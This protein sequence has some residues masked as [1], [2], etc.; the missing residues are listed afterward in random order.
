MAATK[1]LLEQSQKAYENYMKLSHYLLGE[2]APMD[3]KDIPE[4]NPYYEPAKK[5]AEE[6]ELDWDKM[7]HEDSIRV[8]INLL[9]DAYLN[10]QTDE[11]YIPVLTI[12]FK[13]KE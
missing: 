9:S 13:K 4:D 7:S 6:M 1:E 5:M 8:M 3:V 12:S 11:N 2:D 10:I